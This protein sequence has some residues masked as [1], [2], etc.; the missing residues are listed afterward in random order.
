MENLFILEELDLK[1]ASF[2]LTELSNLP[3]FW[4]RGIR[5]RARDILKKWH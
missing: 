3:F 4:N 5:N 1:D 2:Y